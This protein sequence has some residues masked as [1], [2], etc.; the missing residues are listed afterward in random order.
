MQRSLFSLPRFAALVALA[1]SILVTPALAGPPLIC[2]PFDIGAA[3]SLPWTGTS[4]NLS[5]NEGYDTA[6]LVRDTLALLTSDT[7]VIVRMETLRRATLY[8]RKD[9]R[10]AKELITRLH[11]RANA[12][13]TTKPDSL[14]WFDVGYLIEAFGQGLPS[15]RNPAAGLDGHSFITKAL[16]M[17]ADDPEM[18][19]AAAL[20][21]LHHPGPDHVKHA[22]RAI[23]GAKADAL[24]ARNLGLHFLGNA[25]QTV[26]QALARTTGGGEQ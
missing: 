9:P 3:K 17:R 5:G 2:H 16:A 7:P 15:D 26:A 22:Q 14:A 20:V 23:A 21:T 6:N 4:W 13:D 1:V 11:A 10:A 8:A 19:F 12:M 18:E 24:L 25:N